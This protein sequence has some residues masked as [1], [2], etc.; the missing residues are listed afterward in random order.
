M[1]PISIRLFDEDAPRPSERIQ[2]TDGELQICI[3]PGEDPIDI[4]RQNFGA[5]QQHLEQEVS[6]LFSMPDTER[7]FTVKSSGEIQIRRPH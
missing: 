1:S 5:V 6:F 7:E 2:C 3:K 4:L